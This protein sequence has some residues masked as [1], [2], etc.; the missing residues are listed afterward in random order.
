M[1]VCNHKKHMTCTTHSN[2]CHAAACSS[3][4]DGYIFDTAISLAVSFYALSILRL[5]G[6]IE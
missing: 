1:G 3:A 5:L 6:L 4:R 2:C